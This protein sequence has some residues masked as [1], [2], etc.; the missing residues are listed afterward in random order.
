[1]TPREKTAYN[2]HSVD[3]ASGGGHARS[4]GT[5]PGEEK[6]CAERR[7]RL[8]KERAR[9]VSGMLTRF[10]LEN[11]GNNRARMRPASL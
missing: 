6:S 3:A 9:K 5:E 10:R 1:M 8:H 11:A 2:A 7:S 4:P